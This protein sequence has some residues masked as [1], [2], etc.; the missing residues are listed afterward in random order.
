MNGMLNKWKE[1]LRMPLICEV[2]GNEEAAEDI[3]SSAHLYICANCR[4]DRRPP[5]I[6]GL[7]EEDL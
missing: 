2:C 4:E 7:R 6:S 3:P 1:E 5:E